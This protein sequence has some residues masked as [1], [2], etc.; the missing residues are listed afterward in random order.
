MSEE[1]PD[2]PE[3]IIAAI[4]AC[5]TIQ[6]DKISLDVNEARSRILAALQPQIGGHV[7]LC[8]EAIASLD[9]Y[10]PGYSLKSGDIVEFRC[11]IKTIKA[12]VAEKQ[13]LRD[14][15]QSCIDHPGNTSFARQALD[16]TP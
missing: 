8:E 4:L 5:V 9:S 7:E 13:R 11:I 15:L 16:T 12:L 10:G 6:S 1:Q 14:A 2:L 3:R